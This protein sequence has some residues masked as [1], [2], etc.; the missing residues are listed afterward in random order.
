MQTHSRALTKIALAILLATPTITFGQYGPEP[1]DR[2]VVEKLKVEAMDRSKIMETISYLTDVCGPRLTGSPLSDKAADWTVEQLK[3][4]ELENVHLESWGP[5]GRGWTL[6]GCSVN[7]VAPRFTPMIAHVKAWSPSTTRTIRSVPIYIDAKTPE[8]LEKYRGK[9]GRAIVMIGAPRELKALFEPPAQRKTDETLLRL[10]NAQPP[11]PRSRRGS[12]SSS[13]GPARSTG[14]SASSS[15]NKDAGGEAKSAAETTKTPKSAESNAA[16]AGDKAETQSETKT[17]QPEKSAGSETPEAKKDAPKADAK[18]SNETEKT[19]KEEPEDPRAAYRRLMQIRADIWEMAYLEGAAVILEPGR[20]DGGNVFV[21]A[22]TMP[23]KSDDAGEQGNRNSRGPRP[24]ATESTDI[25][26]QAVMAAEHY[27]QLVRMLEKGAKPEIEVDILTRYY[28]DPEAMTFNI[29]AEI[30]G[31]DLKDEVVMLGAHFDSWQAGTG[32]TD[33][34][35]GCGVAMEA[36]RILKAIDAKPR[37]T[38]RLA[39]W[40]GEE[41]GLLGSRAYVAEHFGKAIYGADRSRRNVT[42]ELKP[43]QEKISAYYNLDNGTGAIRGIYLQGN[44]QLRPIFRSWLAPFSEMGA[45]TVTVSNTGGTD[46][47]SFDAVGIPGFQFIQDSVEYNTR[48][49]HSSMD[50]FDRIQEEDVKQASL[51]MATF[52]Y[53]TAMRDELLPRKPMRGQVTKVGQ[54]SAQ[55]ASDDP[56][57]AAQE[58]EKAAATQL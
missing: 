21:S 28:N 17:A 53:Q 58:S 43:E 5:F 9:L 45:S 30:P 38:I 22:V 32:A 42:Y 26:P 25:I 50:V 20:G 4:W 6:E 52:V 44:E 19:N 31:T 23:R 36:I 2:E 3:E 16:K 10:A 51:I 39:L 29:V 33:N 18:K 55:V 56:K 27:N 48:T 57:D 49:H 1:V 11:I 40:T 15:T 34:A 46:H 41:Q 54:E 12:S 7:M 37:R 47:Q 14:N 8:D 35:V 13:R 24:W